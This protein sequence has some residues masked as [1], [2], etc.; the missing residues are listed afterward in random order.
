MSWQSDIKILKWIILLSRLLII[1]KDTLFHQSLSL[2]EDVRLEISHRELL[3]EIDRWPLNFVTILHLGGTS[4]LLLRVLLKLPSFLLYQIH[5]WMLWS[6]IMFTDVCIRTILMSF[7]CRMLYNFL[8]SW[9]RWIQQNIIFQWWL[10]EKVLFLL[11]R[12][13]DHELAIV[14][15]GI[16]SCQSS[17]ANICG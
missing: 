11:L 9:C 12:S 3:F 1:F 16:G 14:S 2:V 5:H 8:L 17:S 6:S 15:R 7:K 13:F 10:S 4:V